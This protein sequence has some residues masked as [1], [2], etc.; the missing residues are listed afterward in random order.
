MSHI[1]SKFLQ[2]TLNTVSGVQRVTR[3]LQSD[4]TGNFGSVSAGLSQEIKFTL[5]NL[6]F[7]DTSSLRFNFYGSTSTATVSG[8][9][10]GLEGIISK[11]V[12]SIDG[13]T[14]CSI[15]NQGLFSKINSIMSNTTSFNETMG[16]LQLGYRTN[17]AAAIANRAGKQ[18]SIPVGYAGSALNSGQLIPCFML[19]KTQISIFLEADSG[20]IVETNDNSASGYI[21]SNCY[22]DYDLYRSEALQ[23]LYYGKQW[24]LKSVGLNH[25]NFQVSTASSSFMISAPYKSVKSIIYVL[26]DLTD[27]VNKYGTLSK[28]S[29]F[30]NTTGS[31]SYQFR[32]NGESIPQSAVSID[33][34]YNIREMLRCFGKT[35]DSSDLNLAW[36]TA[37]NLNTI[38]GF[39]FESSSGSISGADLV[40]QTSPLTLLLNLGAATVDAHPISLDVFVLYDT[41]VSFGGQG[42][43][44][45]VSYQ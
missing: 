21:V 31:S 45:M 1:P 22:L 24:S 19:P 43:S 32:L 26:R 6:D 20:K 7:I 14:A 42:Y 34:Y 27:G 35:F 30:V 29:T 39:N 41:S 16:K 23:Q 3:S 2:K 40:S 28:E 17:L 18:Y 37:S 10:N 8:F 11:V 5:P 9:V 33:G 12:L 36:A 4:N 38:Q 44:Q 13:K 25:Q 15:E